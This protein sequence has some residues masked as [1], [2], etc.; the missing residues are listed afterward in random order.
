MPTS[1][2]LNTNAYGMLQHAGTHDARLDTLEF[3]DNTLKLSWKKEDGARFQLELGGIHRQCLK[4]FIG[5][6]ILSDIYVWPLADASKAAL[7]PAA[8]WRTLLSWAWHP[9]KIPAEITRITLQ[10]PGACLVLCEFSYG[11]EIAVV[12]EKV[13]LSALTAAPDG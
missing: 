11:G 8:A 2:P 9:E 1:I 13:E 6:Q 4:D 5:E 7:I 12:C 3:R 10:H